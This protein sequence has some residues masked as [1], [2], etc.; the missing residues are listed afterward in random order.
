LETTL[1]VIEELVLVGIPLHASEPLLGYA[2]SGVKG[3]SELNEVRGLRGE[4]NTQALRV[5]TV[6]LD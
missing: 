2:S 5:K 3:L 6:K 4:F 1:V